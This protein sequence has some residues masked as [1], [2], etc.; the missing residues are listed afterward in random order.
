MGWN[1]LRQILQNQGRILD[2]LRQLAA[3]QE[4][5]MSDAQQSYQNLS[6]K[7]DAQ[8]ATINTAV[9]DLDAL[10]AEVQ[11][12]KAQLA[13]GNPITAAQLDALSAKI[14]AGQANL[15]GAVTRD[16]P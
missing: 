16:Q 4:K 8:T 11:S 2:E 7:I 13:G 14:D 9:T 10:E 3:N 1:P 15:S 6:D 12:L 5:A